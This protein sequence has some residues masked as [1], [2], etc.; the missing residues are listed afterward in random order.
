MMGL[1]VIILAAGNGKRMASDMPKVLHT[2]GGL[3]MVERVV[4]TAELLKPDGIFVIYGSGGEQVPEA[5]QHLRVTWIKQEKQL[6]TGHAVQKALPFCDEGDQVLVLYGDVPLISVR[7]LQQLR[8]ETPPNGLGLI[9]TE[10]EEPYG[11]GRI[12]RNEMGNI[13][14]IV[15]HKDASQRQRAIKEINTGIL[16]TS[17]AHLKDW[18]PR[19]K[20]KNTQSEFYLTDIVALAVHDGNPVGGVL[21]HCHEEVQGV[22]DRWEQANLERYYQ[23][24]QAK[25]LAYSGVCIRDP[26]RLD[27]RGYAKVGRDVV[28]D[29]NVVLE[30]NVEIGNGCHIGAGVILKDTKLASNVVIKAHSDIEGVDVAK[31]CIIGPFARLRPGVVLEESV[32]IGNFVEIKKSRIGYGSKVSHLSYVGDASVGKDVNIGAGTITCN[33]DGVNKW[34]TTIGD[35]VFVG[36]NTALVAP[37]KVGKNATIASGSVITKDAPPNKLTLSLQLEQRSLMSWK[38]PTSAK[39]KKDS[40]T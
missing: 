22:N 34:P 40:K 1:K 36:S 15:E 18:L 28:L 5:L 38:K 31:N 25:K 2:I 9:V 11:F 19:V 29:V 21:A 13:L 33:Y 24:A 10:L 26:E 23:R 39:K 17:A 30:G 8:Q 7:T 12:I 3:P 37:V 6:G 14:A 20:N 32:R 16:T 4:N 35:N 27:I